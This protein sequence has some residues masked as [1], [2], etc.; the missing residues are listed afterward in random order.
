MMYFLKEIASVFL[1]ITKENPLPKLFLGAYVF[2]IIMNI[3][4]IIIFSKLLID[5]FLNIQY[6]LFKLDYD[7]FN[8]IQYNYFI[9]SV[10]NIPI[11][12]STF[13]NIISSIIAITLLVFVNTKYKLDFNILETLIIIYIVVILIGFI[14]FGIYFIPYSKIVKNNNKI[15]DI[16]YNNID[17]DLYNL[18]VVNGKIINNRLDA[19]INYLN[20]EEELETEQAFLTYVFLD[21]LNKLPEWK[22]KEFLNSY[23]NGNRPHIIR[24]VRQYDNTI[25]TVFKEEEFMNKLNGKLNSDINRIKTSDFQ[26]VLEQ[27]C[28]LDDMISENIF[29]M[30]DNTMDW[31]IIRD[32]IFGVIVIFTLYKLKKI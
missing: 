2:F 32:L 18:L 13:I 19:F 20:K 9:E 14:D 31:R 28:L 1:K 24:L 16:I 23:K 3:L 26:F 29:I 7:Y 30:K 8:F 10:F 6:S 22:K 21:N 17:D 5:V 4:L 11:N 25:I 12:S 27:S 15:D